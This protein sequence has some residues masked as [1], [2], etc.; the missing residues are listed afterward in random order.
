MR[1]GG[2]C[3]FEPLQDFL[4]LARSAGVLE[5]DAVAGFPGAESGEPLR[6]GF[7]GSVD[8][9]AEAE[10]RGIRLAGNRQDDRGYRRRG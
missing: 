10:G 1:P 3:D 4:D 2:A 7:D 8:A 9:D 6:A 5:G